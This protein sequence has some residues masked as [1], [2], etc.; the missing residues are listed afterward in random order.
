MSDISIY[1]EGTARLN[2]HIPTE[3]IEQDI[4]DT[5]HEIAAMRCEIEGF[6][7]LG[8]R[9][10]DMRARARESGIKEREEFIGKLREILKGRK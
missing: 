9:W 1:G 10:A 5:Q 3:E 7:L 6:K 4:L 2:A 8:D